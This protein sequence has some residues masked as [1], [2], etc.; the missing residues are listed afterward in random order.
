MAHHMKFRGIEN[1][2]AVFEC[3][4]CN[5]PIGFHLPETQRSDAAVRNDDGTYDMPPGA[6][7]TEGNEGSVEKSLGRCDK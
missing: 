4:D 2:M 3:Q 1:G 6:L 5:R 7:N